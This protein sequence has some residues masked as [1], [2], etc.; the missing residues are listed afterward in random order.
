[1]S[2]AA[3]QTI[4]IKRVAYLDRERTRKNAPFETKLTPRLICFPYGKIRKKEEK[5]RIPN[6]PKISSCSHHF[7]LFNLEKKKKREKNAQHL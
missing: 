5:Q 7:N 1:M 3:V 4:K 2:F 6:N